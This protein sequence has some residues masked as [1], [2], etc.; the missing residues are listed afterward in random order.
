MTGTGRRCPSRTPRPGELPSLHIDWATLDHRMAEHRGEVGQSE[1]DRVDR[2]V[3][4]TGRGDAERVRILRPGVPATGK[5]LP[6][7][8][9][10]SNSDKSNCHARIGP[11][12]LWRRPQCGFGQ[13]AAF[14]LVGRGTSPGQRNGMA[15]ASSRLLAST[16]LGLPTS[17]STGMIGVH[18]MRLTPS[19]LT[20]WSCQK[21]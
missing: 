5:T 15:T 4:V 13:L 7:P 3:L 2:V 1:L 20:Q 21:V 11:A 19:G 14:P 10:V 12:A 8:D 18:P 6:A 9:V 17:H 16:G